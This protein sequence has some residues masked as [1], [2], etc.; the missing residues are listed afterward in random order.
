MAEVDLEELYDSILEGNKSAIK[1]TV[2]ALLELW[3]DEDFDSVEIFAEET[4]TAEAP[5]KFLSEILLYSESHPDFVEDFV[6]SIDE[7]TIVSETD[8]SRLMEM[9]RSSREQDNEEFNASR[10]GRASVAMNP[11]CPPKLLMELA[12]DEK[13]EIRYRVALNPASSSEILEALVG[14]SY[15]EY[16]EDLADFIEATVALHKN[17]SEALLAK[18]AVSENPIVR[19]AVA[20]NPNTPSTALEQAKLLGVDSNLINH[21]KSRQKIPTFRETRLCWWFGS[22][23]WTLADLENLQTTGVEESALRKFLKAIHP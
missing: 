7:K 15:P 20:C 12:K 3:L 22:S 19:T 9:T 17:S 1:K 2:N 21:P 23:D 6:A 16:L 18:L 11:E 14:G 8:F 5:K 10:C 4:L 13:W